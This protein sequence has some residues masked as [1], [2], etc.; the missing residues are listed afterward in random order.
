MQESKNNSSKTEKSSI[1][2]GTVHLEDVEKFA[3]KL[4]RQNRSGHDKARFSE[5]IV[6]ILS[7]TD[8]AEWGRAMSLAT[9]A[10]RDVINSSRN[11]DV[12]T[13]Y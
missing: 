3:G 2:T 6:D 13:I 1:S 10:A 8:N 4:L 9:E 11:V 12:E 5:Q 7:A